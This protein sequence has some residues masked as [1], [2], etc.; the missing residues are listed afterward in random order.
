MSREAMRYSVLIHR[1]LDFAAKAHHGQFRKSAK[2]KIPYI[3]HC[4]MVGRLLERAGFDEEVV[5]AGILHD[6]VEDSGVSLKTLEKTFTKRVA[7]L[8]EHVT[9]KDK[10]LPWEKRKEK[11]LDHLSGAPF[12]ALAISCADKI[13][14]LWSTVEALR[15]GEDV[16]S[17]LSRGKKLQLER[18]DRLAE[19]FGNRFDHPLRKMFQ[20]ALEALKAESG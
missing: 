14:N 5:T 7:E 4:F 8:V 3:G 16:W 2:E 20:E 9:E 19:L 10:S 1:A 15:T 6:T 11:Y 17:Q 12:E 13:H 18:F